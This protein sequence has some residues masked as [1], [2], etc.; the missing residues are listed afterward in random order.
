MISEKDIDAIHEN[1]GQ[2][3]LSPRELDTVRLLVEGL[4]NRQIGRRLGISTHTAKFHVCNVTRKLGDK[5]RVKA[6][7]LAVR[8][9]LA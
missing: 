4:S 8:L 5:N 1:P 9:G 3:E 7:V 6:A 2:E